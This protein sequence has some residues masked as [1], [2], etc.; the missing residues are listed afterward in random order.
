MKSLTQIAR[1][2]LDSEVC[3]C[4]K[5]KT[6]DKPFCLRCYYQLPKD[7]QINLQRTMSQ[8]FASYY[9]DSYDYLKIEGL[10]KLTPSTEKIE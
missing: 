5:A 8:G 6:K 10:I 4:G 3:A 2:A 9:S 7:H 1:E